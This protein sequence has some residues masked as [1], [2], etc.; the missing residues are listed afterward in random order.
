[1]PESQPSGVARQLRHEAHEALVKVWWGLRTRQ[2]IRPA[3]Y[4]A[5]SMYMRAYVAARFCVLDESCVTDIVD[6]VVTLFL[7]RSAGDWAGL[8]GVRPDDCF[9]ALDDVAFAR[10]RGPT[11]DPVAGLASAV[12]TVPTDAQ[13][14]GAIFGGG[15]T[16]DDYR[17][18]LTATQIDGQVNEYLVI[19]QTLDLHNKFGRMPTAEEVADRLMG[20]GV[21]DDMVTVLQHQFADRLRQERDRVS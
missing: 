18:A 6:E 13:L 7:A 5:L 12:T 21:T 3:E 10:I 4:I 14:I 9:V 19:T 11:G 8:P 16:D 1:M 20:R 2:A 15:L 17:R